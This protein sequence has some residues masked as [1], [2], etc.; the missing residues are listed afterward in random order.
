MSDVTP[1]GMTGPNPRNRALTARGVSLWLDD[2]SRELLETG[3]FAEYV[4]V[5]SVTGATSNPSIFAKALREPERYAGQLAWLRSRGEMSADELFLALA[6]T[7]VADAAKL[8]RPVYERSNHSDGYVSFECTPDVAN[9]AQATVEQGLTLAG[10]LAAH[11]NTMIKVPATDAGVIAIEELTAAGVNVNVTLLFS[12]ARYQQIAEAYLRGL[13][14]RA[15]AGLALDHV[16]SVASFFVSRVDAKADARLQY[17][18]TLVGRVAIVNA[19][20][21]YRRSEALFSGSRWDALAAR[22]ANIQRPLWASMA[23]KNE[24]Y[25]DVRYLEAL[26]LPGSVATVPQTTLHAFADHGRPARPARLFR[27]DLNEAEFAKAAWTVDLEGIARELEEEGLAAFADAYA[28]ILRA[29]DGDAAEVRDD[30][31]RPRLTALEVRS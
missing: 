17:G 30:F 11:P 22:G 25:Q 15:A 28:E 2:L 4:D 5:Y 9:D 3:R 29:I 26:A 23:P 14:Q 20:A 18:S 1:A 24:R 10:R 13:E 19:K 7:D 8:L 16:H 31:G 21:A 27:E 12:L 6:L